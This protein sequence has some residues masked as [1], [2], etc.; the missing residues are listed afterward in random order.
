MLPASAIS[1]VCGVNVEYKN[2]NAG[3]GGFLPQRLAVIGTGN[4]DSVYSTEKYEATGSADAVAK[5]FGYGSPLHLAARQLFPEGGGGAIFPVTF[6]PLAPSAGGAAAEGA[7][8]CSG[9]AEAAGNGVLRIGGIQVEFAILKQQT[10]A[11]ILPSIKAA[12]AAKLEMPV[13]AGDIADD[14]LP[15]TAK[16]KGASGNAIKVSIASE[17]PGVVF[18]VTHMTGGAVD[19]DAAPALAL[20]GQVWET[21]ILSCFAWDNESRLDQYQVFSEGRWGELEKKPCLIAHGCVDDFA[22]RTAITDQRKTDYANFLIQSTGSDE[23]PFV[24]A[25]KGLLNDI[26][27]TAN[28]NPPTGYHGLLTG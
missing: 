3:A 16:W 8:A 28:S 23:L 21:F 27:T 12:I 1:R 26:M 14:E 6:Y 19:S 9:A 15:L 5:R 2:F 18:D 11:E 7:V 20:I 4:D 24:I 22:T 25:A 13:I 17:V 10:A